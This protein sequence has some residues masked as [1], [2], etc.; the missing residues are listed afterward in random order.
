MRVAVLVVF[1]LAAAAM[2]MPV[3]ADSAPYGMWSVRGGRAKIKVGNCEN[4]K[5]K[6]CAH[7]VWLRPDERRDAQGRPRADRR[8]KNASL[9][10]RPILGLP[11]AYDMAPAGPGK[12]QGK[13][14]DPE[15]GSEYKGYMKLM[16]DGR[17]KVT[18]C[19]VAFLC[20]SK[21]WRPLK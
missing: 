3:M 9:R 2:L 20:E 21:Y 4:D 14:Y 6:L 17:M 10:N 12:W 16:P 1:M 18:G 7:I 15:R 5:T 13:V 11:V 19:L 8:N